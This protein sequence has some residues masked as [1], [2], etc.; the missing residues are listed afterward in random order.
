MPN[1]CTHHV[2]GRSSVQ[3]ASQAIEDATT[4]AITLKLAGKD[5]VVL[6]TRTWESIRYVK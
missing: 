2:V 6:G 1:P 4:L 3:G 5:N